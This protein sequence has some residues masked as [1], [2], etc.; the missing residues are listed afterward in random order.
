MLIFPFLHCSLQGKKKGKSFPDHSSTSYE[1]L[2]PQ[3]SPLRT[4]FSM[5]SLSPVRVKGILLMRVL[6]GFRAKRYGHS[7][8][9]SDKVSIHFTLQLDFDTV[10]HYELWYVASPFYSPM[11]GSA[12]V[13]IELSGDPIF[14]QA[15]KNHFI[16]HQVKSQ[17]FRHSTVAYKASSKI[18]KFISWIRKEDC[19]EAYLCP[20]EWGEKLSLGSPFIRRLGSISRYQRHRHFDRDSFEAICIGGDPFENQGSVINEFMSVNEGEEGKAVEVCRLIIS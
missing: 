17:L 7:T 19:L 15:V 14:V 3:N 16:S 4:M 5:Y 9:E 20:L 18:C 12:H 8:Q 13:K 2:L 11:L 1:E 6:D 10:L